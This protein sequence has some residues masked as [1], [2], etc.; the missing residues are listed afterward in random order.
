MK[1]FVT[2]ATGLIGSSA[3]RA[4]VAAGHEV[5]GLTSRAAGRAAIEAMG[6]QAVVGDMRDA[7]A[8][9]DAVS[10]A[11]GVLHAAAALP[12][13]MRLSQ[14]DVDTF[15][16]A[17]VDAVDALA[18]VLGPTCRA[19][20]ITSGAY[21]YGDTGD[22]PADEGRSTERAH[23]VMRLKVAMEK[24]MLARAQAG[25]IP[26]IVV[27]PGLIYGDGS[28]WAKLYLSA[29][30]AG[31]RAMM[32]GAGQNLISFVHHDDVGEAYRRILEHPVPGAIYNVADDSP[33]RLGVVVRAQ[34]DALG[35]PPPRAIP[36]W[37]IRLLAGSLGAGPTL[38]NTALTN[39]ALKALGWA[40]KYRSYREGIP[41]LS[42]AI[43]REG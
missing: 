43:R 34:A 39:D 22:T 30:K 32:P 18:S 29:M 14:S 10:G 20:V 11:D 40:P 26:A 19:F 15:M 25:E 42:A 5:T 31:K 23:P 12:D 4:L 1:V 6:A 9:R 8:Y 3:L 7:S 33:E 24:R 35:A 21:V 41:A 16:Q 17:D 27:R 38:V 36:G 2:G 13:K 28:L 37:L